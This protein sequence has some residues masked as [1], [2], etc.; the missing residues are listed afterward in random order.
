MLLYTAVS[1][2]LLFCSTYFCYHP[3]AHAGALLPVLCGL[4]LHGVDIMNKTSA[5]SSEIP[6]EVEKYP[7]CCSTGVILV[8][9]PKVYIQP[10][11]ATIG[12]IIS[13]VCE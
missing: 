5:A 1:S 10:C 13:G 2:T 4:R 8:A 7:D 11:L 12:I 3:Y 6:E 9:M